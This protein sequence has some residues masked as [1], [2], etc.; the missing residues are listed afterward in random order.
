MKTE[1]ELLKN[2]WKNVWVIEIIP[3]YK[4]FLNNKNVLLKT[5][6]FYSTSRDTE[7]VSNNYDND[8][9]SNAMIKR[10]TSNMTF[11]KGSLCYRRP[12]L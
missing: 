6:D 8:L 9:P 3:A 12:T 11:R 5:L 1:E 7:Y 10:H 2:Y 4:T